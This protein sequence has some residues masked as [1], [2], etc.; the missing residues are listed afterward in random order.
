MLSGETPSSC[1]H[2]DPITVGERTP[3]HSKWW[4]RSADYKFW[5]FRRSVREQT[6]FW[7]EFSE[8][9]KLAFWAWKTLNKLKMDFWDF[10]WRA[11]WRK[12]RPELE[13]NLNQFHRL[14][15]PHT[16]K[17][18]GSV[19]YLIKCFIRQTGPWELYATFYCLSRQ[20]FLIV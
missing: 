3:E 8:V 9:A 6:P 16:E 4:V 19:T 17:V 7:T 20:L 10:S 14:P 12:L 15:P 2:L 13:L 11:S 18:D 5:R 1:L